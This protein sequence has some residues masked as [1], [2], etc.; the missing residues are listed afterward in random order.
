MPR[1]LYPGD[2]VPH[3][4]THSIGCWVV[5]GDGLDALAKKEIPSLLL[6]GVETQL[7]SL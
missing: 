5:P 7:S 2:R 4:G 3:P 6:T 1:Q